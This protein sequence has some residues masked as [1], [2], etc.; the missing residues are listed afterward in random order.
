MQRTKSILRLLENVKRC[1]RIRKRLDDREEPDCRGSVSN[2][3]EWFTPFQV[4]KT[5][6]QKVTGEKNEVKHILM[7]AGNKFKLVM[8]HAMLSVVQNQVTNCAYDRLDDAAPETVAIITMVCK[9]K[10]EPKKFR[11]KSSDWY[12]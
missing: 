5:I 12:G 11:Q 2:Y 4:M 7:D 8:G 6:R 3:F 10:Y 1:K 9:I